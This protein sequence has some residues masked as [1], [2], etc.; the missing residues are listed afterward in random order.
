MFDKYMYVGGHLL[1][2]IIRRSTLHGIISLSS[3]YQSNRNKDISTTASSS[4]YFQLCASTR[5]GHIRTNDLYPT[6]IFQYHTRRV[7]AECP[8]FVNCVQIGRRI[9]PQIADLER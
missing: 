4:T 9:I 7:V 8:L 6:F 3:Q 5:I 1:S 2:T